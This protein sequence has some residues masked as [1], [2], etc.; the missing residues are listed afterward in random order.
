MSEP[1]IAQKA[2]ERPA[3]EP[4]YTD[5]QAAKIIDPSGELL[6]P[7]AIRTELEKG[8]LVGTNIAGK[9]LYRRSDLLDFL[10]IARRCHAPIEDHASPSARD[11]GG[12]AVSITSRGPR[13]VATVNRPRPSTQRVLARLRHTSP[14]GCTSDS[15]NCAERQDAQVI[16]IKS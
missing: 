4:Y 9:W 7:S 12:P 8:R 14:T 5:I 2:D 1:P 15:E 16:P 3:I 6:G 10:E 13:E 11:L